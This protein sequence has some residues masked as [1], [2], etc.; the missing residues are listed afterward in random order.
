MAG[1]G[2]HGQCRRENVDDI[3]LRFACARHGASE[4]EVDFS[5]LKQL[6]EPVARGD[7]EVQPNLRQ[8][9]GGRDGEARKEA[10]VERARNANPDV[11]RLAACDQRQVYLKALG[12]LDQLTRALGDKFAGSSQPRS[13][14]R[15]L[16][17]P[18]LQLVLKPRDAFGET[19]L[20]DAQPVGSLGEAS[21]IVDRENLAYA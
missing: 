2:R 3:Q 18:D 10:A 7:L 17:K 19:G 13:A 6:H 12:L 11:R 16:D 1:R 14:R 5:R 15:P 9:V 4:H 20:R 8:H 21:Q